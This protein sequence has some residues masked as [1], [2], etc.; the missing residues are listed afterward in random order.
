M[1][2]L[3]NEELRALRTAI[4]HLN[5]MLE[6]TQYEDINPLLEAKKKQYYDELSYMLK[7]ME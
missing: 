5:W 6:Q 3:Q 7:E 1:M 2:N 4:E